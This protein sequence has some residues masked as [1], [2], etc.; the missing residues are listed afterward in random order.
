M[1]LDEKLK[2]VYEKLLKLR[3]R[4]DLSLR[5]TKYLRERFVAADGKERELKIR[6]YQVQMILHLQAMARFVCGDDTGLGKTL[7]SIASL[8]YLWE[9]EPNT[10][11]LVLTKKSAV[12][13][14]AS[15]VLRFTQGVKVLVSK[16]TP[17][18]RERILKEFE[19]HTD[20]PIV[21]VMNYRSACQDIRHLVDWKSYVLIADEAHVFKN[22]KAQV[23]KVVHHMANQAS[24]CWA[25]T[26]TVIKNNLLE[27]YGVY[28]V[29]V[30]GLFQMSLHQFMEMFCILQMQ[31]VKNRQIPMVVGYQKGAIAQFKKMIDP[32]F[33]GRPKHAVAKD[34]PVLTTKIVESSMTPFQAVKYQEA[35]SGILALGTGE[36]KEVSPLTKV[37]YCQEIVNHPGLIDLDEESEKLNTL[38]EL[39]GED[40]ELEGEKVIIY[41]RFERMVSIAYE[42]LTRMG[43][44]CVRVTGKESEDERAAAQAAFQDAESDTKVVFI[45]AAGGDSINL[46]TAKALI[47]YDTPWSAG[48]YLQILGRMIRI[49]SV[50][51]RVYAMHLVCK[52]TIDERVLKVMQTKLTLVEAIIG[53]RILG[54]NTAVDESVLM[55]ENDINAVYNALVED[56]K[57]MATD[58]SKAGKR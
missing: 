29:V 2:A 44:K 28:R 8:A 41:S 23:H 50:H 21:L 57:N 45:T 52:G 46:Q 4:E 9:R 42:H 26:A 14:W 22:P 53:K 58:I 43:I 16:G 10:K 51:D 11:A 48:D 54:E 39:L 31:R 19:N 18:Q 24:R 37:T 55:V 47:F 5:P 1:P 38:A 27:G 12:P 3:E 35:L 13:Q 32:F 49:G 30:P 20:G 40:G 7:E 25:L 6:Y 56:A 15:E 36:E 17:A 34:L 33:L